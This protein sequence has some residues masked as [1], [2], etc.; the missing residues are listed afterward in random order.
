MTSTTV[1]P[2]LEEHRSVWE[3]KPALRLIYEDYHR[4]MLAAMP[5]GGEGDKI[6]EI[7]SGSGHLREFA[8]DVVTIDVLPS[9]WIDAVADAHKL[10][11][12]DNSF[13]GMVMLDVLHH[14]ERPSE[15]FAETVRLLKPGGRF[16]FIEPGITALSWLFYNFIHEEPVDMSVNPMIDPEPDPFRDPFDANQGVPTLMFHRQEHRITFMER[17]PELRMVSRGWLSLAAYP[18]TGGFQK[19]CLIPAAL[20]PGALKLEQAIMP[21]IGQFTAFRLMVV[22]EKKA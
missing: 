15:F 13:D 3:K 16:A 9:P 4:R 6:L 22:L 21:F 19:W 18:M 14:L 10:P 5:N 8:E 20:V 2:R 7:G 17:F 12:A 11:F 1:D